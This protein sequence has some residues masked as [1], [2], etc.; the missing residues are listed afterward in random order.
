MRRP[1][2]IPPTARLSR[3]AA[4]LLC[5]M[6]LLCAAFPL[7]AQT[8][9]LGSL[10]FA[11]SGAPA[12]QDDFV[13]GVLLLHS[14][15]YDDAAAAFRRAQEADPGFALAWWG[16]AMTHNHPIWAEQDRDA[17]RAILARAPSEA[18]TPREAMYLRA[19]DE[20]Y[21]EGTKAERDRR[22]ML[23][24]R[25]LHEAHPD[26]REARAFYALSILGLTNGV[27]DFATYMRAAAVAQPL[28]EENPEHPGA[29]HYLI[30]AFD[31]PIHA[32]LGLS[33]AHAYGETVRDAAHAQHMTSHIFLA[34]GMWDDVVRANVNATRVADEDRARR[35][36]TVPNRCGHYPYWLHYGHLMRE[37]WDAATRIMAQCQR[38][39]ADPDRDDRGYYVSTRARQILDTGE[40][41]AA[42]RWTQDLSD[43]P[44]SAPAYDFV[45]AYA[46]LERG[47][48]GPATAT[49]DA[50]GAE[51][52][53]ARREIMRLELAALL[54]L[55]GGGG[56]EAVAL[57]REAAA[58]E[59][60]LPLEFGPPASLKPP[61]ELLGEVL[62]EL[63]RPGEA[64]EAFQ[65]ALALTPLRTP[66]LRGL[67]AAARAA[68][69]ETLAHDTARQIREI[70]P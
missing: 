9:R 67:E 42:A 34:L 63:G 28:F 46:A 3:A 53:E 15:E 22:Y 38:N 36:V 27:R 62:L 69:M 56:D 1:G 20:L 51:L 57:L 29:A 31:D 35:G 2:P 21:G 13:R 8:E 23:A 50:W 58:L 44:A 66:A 5:A 45:N 43:A 40:W 19:L 16:E 18:L 10:T 30:H 37:E 55:H 64:V 60:S 24:M 25:R 47:D 54:A 17:A 61:H 4:R 48:P 65:G 32:P 11:N 68:G 41:G 49:L 52:D 14:F 33:A 12:A 39:Q 6:S 26:D 70:V 7:S 59:E